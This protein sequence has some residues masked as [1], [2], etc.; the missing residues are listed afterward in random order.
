MYYSHQWIID[1][2]C[3]ITL[4]QMQGEFFVLRTRSVVC[5]GG[6]WKLRVTF[7]LH[8]DF[9]AQ[10]W[11]GLCRWLDVVVELPANVMMSYGSLIGSGRNKRMKKG[12]AIVWLAF[13]RTIW[14][15]RND[16]T[17]N[18]VAGVVE[19]AVDLIQRLSW[20]WFLNNAATGS[21]L[22]YEWVWNPGDCMLR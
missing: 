18:N 17:F 11:Y 16:K 2:C 13:I 7:F 10:I 1:S 20:Q 15:A 4:L 5:A 6:K 12:F 3:G 9:A 8:C 19:D 14:R 21:C 22:L